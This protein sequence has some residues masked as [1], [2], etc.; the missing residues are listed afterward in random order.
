M[1]YYPQFPAKQ[2]ASF[3]SQI[4]GR[5]PGLSAHE[6]ALMITQIRAVAQRAEAIILALLGDSNRTGDNYGPC[7]H[8]SV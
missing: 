5:C 3:R 7:D 1:G 6:E 2:Q 4:K 8:R